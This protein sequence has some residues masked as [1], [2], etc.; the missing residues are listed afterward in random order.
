MKNFN[1]SWRKFHL[2]KDNIGGNLPKIYCLA[3]KL[4]TVYPIY[5]LPPSQ[6]KSRIHFL[7]ECSA[8]SMTRPEIWTHS[9]KPHA[10]LHP[11]VLEFLDYLENCGRGPAVSKKG[12]IQKRQKSGKSGQNRATLVLKQQ[13]QNFKKSAK[14]PFLVLHWRSLHQNFQKSKA[15]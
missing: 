11:C 15:F 13:N 9:L 14:N 7:S 1:G 5:V 3:E 6:N 2:Q 12:W 8:T 4:R 10:I